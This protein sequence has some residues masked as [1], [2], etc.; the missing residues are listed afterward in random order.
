MANKDFRTAMRQRRISNSNES[1]QENELDVVGVSSLVAELEKS[2][3]QLPVTEIEISQLQDNP[4][5]YL[6]RPDLDP[7][8]LEELANSIRQNGF[9]GALLARRKRGRTI[10]YELAYGHRRREAA[11]LVGLAT[12][13]VKVLELTDGEMARIMASENFSREDLTPMGEA[14]VVGLLSTTQNMSAREISEAIGKSPKWVTLRVAL[15]EAPEDIK[16]MVE[17][18]PDTLTHVPILAKFGTPQKRA[19]LIERVLTNQLTRAK[20]QEE[21]ETSRNERP[22]IPTKIVNDVTR[23]PQ[24]TDS[25]TN[26][27]QGL[28]ETSPANTARWEAAL[29]QLN[30]ALEKLEQ[31][32]QEVGRETIS[33]NRNSLESA[34]VRLRVIMKS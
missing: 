18:K 31:T 19:P 24:R 22:D 32:A 28:V 13:P 26:H 20:L 5:Q 3:V 9:Y 2:S 11:R 6:A 30:R 10:Q 23:L 25:Y 1:D 34:V 29:E 21:I 15:Y 16:K 7:E 8:N 17:Q 14:N 27:N 12:L 33:E 4:F